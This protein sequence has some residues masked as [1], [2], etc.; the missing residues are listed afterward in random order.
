MADSHPV[1]NMLWLRRLFY[2]LGAV[3]ALIAVAVATIWLF[4]KSPYGEAL[5]IDA[6]AG[7]LSETRAVD[8][9]VADIEGDLP[10]RMTLRDVMLRDPSGQWLTID[11]IS[12]EWSPLALLTGRVV[13]NRID[14]GRVDVERL[15]D[16]PAPSRASSQ[17][18]DFDEL[19]AVLTRLRLESAVVEQL[20]LPWRIGGQPVFGRLTAS[21]AVNDSNRPE[22]EVAIDN[23][24]SGGRIDVTAVLGRAGTVA[25]SVNGAYADS[26]LS[27]R[28]TV[29]VRTEAVD[30]QGQAILVSSLLPP[31]VNVTFDS[32]TAD[33]A[34]FGNLNAPQG[35]IGYSVT[36]VRSGEARFPKLDGIAEGQ[37]TG[38]AVAIDVA[39]G[40]TG[41]SALAPDLGG[42]LRDE[43]L[44]AL[45][46]TL[47]PDADAPL[48]IDVTSA[49]LESGTVSL[50][51]SGRAELETPSFSGQATLSVGGAG[52]MIGW[53]DDSSRTALALTVQSLTPSGISATLSG[54]I[55]DVAA[56][57]TA[58]DRLLDGQLTVAGTL[59]VQGAQVSVTD[60]EIT[61][62]NLTATATARIA[63]DS[64]TVDAS[65]E[66]TVPAL[67]VVSSDLSGSLTG[68]GT[69]RGPLA[70]PAL[71]FRLTSGSVGVRQETFSEIDL[72]VS[73]ETSDAS[74]PVRVSGAVT[75][76][77]GGL[78]VSAGA[79]VEP[80]S[81]ISVEDIS[82]TGAGVSLTGAL[83]IDLVTSL[84]IGTLSATFDSLALP[85][86][87]TGV[88]LSGSGHAKV[89]LTA[90]DD[91][92]TVFVTG[93]GEGLRYQGSRA[94]AGSA[95]VEGRW[96]GGDV[97]VIDIAVRAGNGFYAG[98]AIAEAEV[99]ASGPLSELKVRAALRAP[100]DSLR[101]SAAG[102][103]TVADGETIV[104]ADSLAVADDWGALNLVQPM[105]V[106]VSS[107]RLSA[108][109]VVLSANGGTLT[110]AFDLDRSAGTVAAKVDAV[111]LP[112]DILSTIDPDLPVSG[113]FSL[114]A[115]IEGALA[116]PSGTVTLTTT[117][118]SLPDTGLDG[119]GAR[120]VAALRD[121]RVD[122]D[123]TVDGLSETPATLTGSVPFILDLAES[124]IRAPLEE[125]AE[126][127]LTWA[128]AIDPIWALLPLVAHRMTGE[129]DIDL[130]L[131]GTL[132]EPRVSGY[133][134]LTRGTYENL[135][136]GTL[137][138]DVVAELDAQSLSALS[139]TTT[140]RDGDDGSISGSG[141]ITRD[142]A[143]DLSGDFTLTLNNARLVRRDDVKLRGE[144]SVTYTLTPERDR[145]DGDISVRSAEISLNAS[146]V[147]SV[148]VLDV[149]DPDAP[150]PAA[151][152]RAGKETD[153]NVHVNAPSGIDVVGR[154][155][156]SEWTADI[157]VGG[158]LAAPELTGSLNV[159]RGEFTF[160]GELFALTR[161]Q[162]SF[163]GGGEIDPGLSVVASRATGG[164]TARV[165][166]GGRA[167]APTIALASDPPLPQDE[168]LAR[169]LFG[170]SA[171]QLGP[172]EAVQLANA[173]T[174]LTGLA[175][176]GGVVGTL[177]RGVGLD[178][179]RFGSD[180][181]GSTV[182]VGERLSRNIFV[183]VEQGLEGQGSQ[184]IIEWQ[185]TDNLAVKSTTHQDTG[186]DIGLKWSRDY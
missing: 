164:V 7:L 10:G 150:A 100:D 68:R 22:F 123:V 135:D 26:S 29:N 139:L 183:G 70:G 102:L 47:T 98:Q 54:S 153:L 67:D 42:I 147:D 99:D 122:I 79:M 160:L 143:G 126:L 125:Q 112:F 23:A 69:V 109:D 121:R 63:L 151:R 59:D 27:L 120:L 163:T 142:T 111:A 152:V 136:L 179:L 181:G 28:G 20:T 9:E 31:G 185:L 85:A 30:A 8:V 35:R 33:I 131:R 16:L 140:A 171:G 129:A 62:N 180:A 83:D 64:E 71:A 177:R 82:V 169:I 93:R 37:W 34:V 108:E 43:V 41:L 6:I 130:A 173:A 44:Y 13:I 148:P 4:L 32:A 106:R 57:N 114:A 5:V 75:I 81:A 84:T 11:R 124:R 174:E 73:A 178:V 176:R 17:P 172:L 90:E 127:D 141:T 137:L 95:D 104:R 12:V 78:A 107:D 39:G 3:A 21:L 94:G 92:Q 51:L 14:A 50:G 61:G 162:V 166:L 36:G 97:P 52:R 168:I 182:V 46:G 19:A 138:N 132:A 38:N 88:P 146:Y 56:P 175:G 113:H 115:Q 128:G 118:I 86:A 159:L 110:A 155:L 149:V 66:W 53:Q 145:L 65:T 15:P 103:L 165:E 1:R 161:G 18:T 72:Q 170:K 25:V 158:T 105:T 80:G 91:T 24:Q 74:W 156:D 144:G 49:S 154:G 167:S 58:V 101:A 60:F 116:S 55:A 117:D 186:S 119:V 134:R 133:A 89:D 2:S 48:D 77:E 45:T 96:T 40:I 157:T 76:A 87:L 184:L